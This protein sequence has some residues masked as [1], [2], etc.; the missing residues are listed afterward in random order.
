M[1]AVGDILVTPCNYSQTL[2]KAFSLNALLIMETPGRY[3][4]LSVLRSSVWSNLE[5]V[6]PPHIS[7]LQGYLITTN[8]TLISIQNLLSL[9]QYNYNRRYTRG[10]PS[11]NCLQ[12]SSKFIFVKCTLSYPS[13]RRDKRVYKYCVVTCVRIVPRKWKLTHKGGGGG[14]FFWATGPCNPVKVTP[15]PF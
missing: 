8:C 5:Q 12:R 15:P 9:R 14:S 2:N 10:L 11:G 6:A 4:P 13:W 1:E 7:H 3:F